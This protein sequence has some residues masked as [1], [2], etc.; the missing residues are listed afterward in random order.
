MNPVS[1]LPAIVA[2]LLALA[3]CF[4]LAKIFGSPADPKRL[5]AIDGLRGYL[6]FFV[7]LHHACIWH[8]YLQTGRWETPP[9]N[10][11]THF[12]QSSVAVFF[13][14]TG[15]LFFSKILEGRTMPIDWGRL[16]VSRFLRLVPL[17]LLAMLLLF[18]VAAILSGGVAREP[19]SRLASELLAWLVFTIAGAPDING[20]EHSFT[21]VAGVTWSL[22]YEW[23]FY[24]SLPLLALA[25]KLRPPA[26]FVALGFCGVAGLA[27]WGPEMIPLLSFL[28]GMAASILARSG[29]F[30][31]FAAGMV[32]S[33][34]VSVCLVA[35]VAFFHSANELAPLLLL[36]LAFA[37]MAAGCGLFGILDHPLSRTLGELAY[38]MYLLH[39]IALFVIFKLVLGVQASKSLSPVQHWIVVAGIT[40]IL[41]VICFLA[42]RHVEQP[43]MRNTTRVTGW[44]RARF[45]KARGNGK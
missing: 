22:A 33:L 17:Y 26:A 12:G 41:V 43:A 5:A 36:S 18:M 30:R 29:W 34:L 19:I 10:L 13:M 35:A 23:F 15:F 7:F 39:G 8:F 25:V 38:S 45:P 16:Y 20:I 3:T 1:P 27:M 40:P 31:R 28:A 11:Y 6:A 9:S 37:L 21:I 2:L 4:L 24:F 42:A 44:L 32:S 14:I